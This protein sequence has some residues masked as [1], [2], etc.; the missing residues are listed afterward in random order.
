MRLYN[1]TFLVGL[2]MSFLVFWAL[3]QF[4]PPVGLGEES[5]FVGEEVIYGVSHSGVDNEFDSQ[6]GEKEKVVASV[7]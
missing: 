4:F 7:V 5:S 6:D 3:N 2:A 1:L